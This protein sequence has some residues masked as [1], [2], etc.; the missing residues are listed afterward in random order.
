MGA[1]PHILVVSALRN[2]GPFVID[3]LA[4][5]LGAG[6]SDFL[7]YTNACDDGTDEMLDVLAQA[8]VLRHIRHDPDPG[9]SIQWQAFRQAWKSDQRKA[10]EWVMVCDVDEYVNIHA[11]QGRLADLIA[12][13]PEQTDAIAMPWRLYGANGQIDFI[14]R[15][16]TAQFTRCMSPEGRFP[17]G[18]TFFKSLIR[19][20]GPFNQLGVHRPS[21]KDPARAPVPHWVDGAG[22]PLPEGI[23]RRAGRLSLYGTGIG[24]SLVEINHYS[25]RSVQSF[26]VK[27]ARGLPNHRDRAIDLAYWA[28]RNFNT[29]EN[30]SIARMAPATAAAKAALMAIPGV[31]DLHGRSVE[32][33]QQKIEALLRQPGPFA[34]YAQILMM[35]DSVE[36]PP[37]AAQGLY[38]MYQRL[39]H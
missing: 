39:D 11:G 33:H 13:V 28:E 8:G 4:H 23:A 34:L 24:R 29:E 15:P 35:G 1:A 19:T 17:L 6:V 37:E 31:A 9:S 27:S 7:L 20:A 14:D 18:A 2:E 10:A 21:Q 16:V 36:L 25:L 26:L 22:H 5:L 30:H 32:R 38:R 3:W 12:A